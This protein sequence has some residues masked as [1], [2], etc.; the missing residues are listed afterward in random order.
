VQLEA[1]VED[2]LKDLDA[3][4]LA[5]IVVERGR[6]AQPGDIIADNFG[7]RRWADGIIIWEKE[8]AWEPNAAPRRTYVP[9]PQPKS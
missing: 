4:K 3:D 2:A 9:H 1:Q 8:T 5:E 7:G 6:E